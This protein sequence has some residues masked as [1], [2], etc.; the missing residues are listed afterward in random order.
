MSLLDRAIVKA[1]RE[2]H[3]QP[4]SRP[5]PAAVE[6]VPAAIPPA[7]PQAVEPVEPV[8]RG[9]NWPR[10]TQQLLNQ[11]EAGF[12]HLA[13]QLLGSAAER[14]EKCVA[15]FGTTRGE[16]CSSVLLTLAHVLA[17][18][19]QPRIL[20]VDA[21]LEHPSLWSQLQ[22]GTASTHKALPAAANRPLMLSGSNVCVL[23]PVEKTAPDHIPEHLSRLT[24]TLAE[25]R[26][27]FDLILI[28]AGVLV[29]DQTIRNS[30]LEANINAAI[31]VI[32]SRQRTAS[33]LESDEDRRWTE[34]GISWLGMIETFA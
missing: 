24:G 29:Q 15:F 17:R 13:R 32:S 19:K 21:D 31:A 30:W 16:G 8:A 27:Q 22:P 26:D 10:I 12:Q 2:T 1:Y 14:H 4:V 25:V 3:S 34:A 6:P 23:A 33:S 20:L 7:N 5:Q 9:W 28:D 11:S 18:L